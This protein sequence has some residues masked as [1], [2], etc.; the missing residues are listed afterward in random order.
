MSNRIMPENNS[1]GSFVDPEIGRHIIYNDKRLLFT[2]D[3]QAFQHIDL[4]N[5]TP[6]RQSLKLTCAIIIQI[7]P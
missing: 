2:L 7:R 6:F 4:L 1:I 3:L 5:I